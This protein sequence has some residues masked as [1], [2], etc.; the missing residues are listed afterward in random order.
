MIKVI[1][2]EVARFI[3]SRFAE[4]KMSEARYEDLLSEAEEY[5]QK[6]LSLLQSI[7]Q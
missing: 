5:H 6:Y 1:P 7:L 4:V 2:K 3:Q